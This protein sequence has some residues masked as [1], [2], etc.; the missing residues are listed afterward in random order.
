MLTNVTNCAICEISQI[1]NCVLTV[2]GVIDVME[3]TLNGEDKNL[4]LGIYEVPVL[5]GVDV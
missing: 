5:E 3:T 1:E 2:S 4:T